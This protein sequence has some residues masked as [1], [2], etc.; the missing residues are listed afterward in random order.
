MTQSTRSGLASLT[1]A[2]LHSL[3]F[4]DRAG[5]VVLPSCKHAVLCLVDGLGAHLLSNFSEKTP[6]L[7]SIP[8]S[9]GGQLLRSGFPSTTAA[10]LASLA[11]AEDSG[12]HGIVGASFSIENRPFNPLAWQFFDPETGRQEQ[13][14]TGMEPIVSSRSAW[15]EAAKN[16]LLI[17]AYLPAA[18]SGSSYTKEVFKGANVIPVSN[19]NDLIERFRA[20]FERVDRTFSYI[21][22]GDLDFCGHLYGPGSQQ[23]LKVLSDIDQGIKEIAECIDENT[24]LI[25]TAD[26]GMTTLDQAR[27]IDFDLIPELQ[28]GVSSLC[29]DIRARHIYLRDPDDA[30]V[31]E[32][33]REMLGAD[34]L[35]LTRKEA[36][37]SGLFGENTSDVVVKRIGDFLAIAHEGAGVIRSLREP[38]QTSWVGHHGALTDEE[39]LVPF[40]FTTGAEA[41]RVGN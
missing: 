15:L 39:Q 18:I 1:N 17:N 30:S 38:F 41:G 28:L 36:L 21:Y 31:L 33:W 9:G 22:F 8:G 13:A 12:A 3:G 26:H 24:V 11:T 6:Y 2:V 25:V 14:F 20:S 29:G 16:G 37:E 34:F 4:S 23:W 40:I 32:R 35:L 27:T 7:K 10:S 19:T 5:D